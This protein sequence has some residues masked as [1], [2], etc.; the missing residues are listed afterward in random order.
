M[1]SFPLVLSR[2]NL[3]RSYLHECAADAAEAEDEA[4]DQ[5][6][7]L[8]LAKDHQRLE[9][10][11]TVQVPK[12]DVCEVFPGPERCHKAEEPVNTEAGMEDRQVHRRCA[13][14]EHLGE[15]A[16]KRGSHGDPARLDEVRFEL[17]KRCDED[18]LVRALIEPW[19]KL[20]LPPS[21]GDAAWDLGHGFIDPCVSAHLGDSV[22]SSI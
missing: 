10:D 8:E 12:V 18:L 21:S 22:K 9:V 6:Q 1:P 3:H 5:H 7:D 19:R 20:L 11:T 2:Q 15:Y 13:V 16:D 14:A 4:A 17:L